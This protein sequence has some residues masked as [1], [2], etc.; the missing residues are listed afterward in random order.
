MKFEQNWLRGFRAGRLKMLTDGQTDG[1]R[2]KSDTIAHPAHSSGKLTSET[3]GRR[4]NELK[5]R[6]S[7]PQ[8]LLGSHIKSVKQTYRADTISMDNHCQI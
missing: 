5:Q 6:L 1:W 4:R 3:T 7:S 8:F 2:T